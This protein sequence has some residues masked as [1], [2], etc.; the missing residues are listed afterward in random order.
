M[1]RTFLLALLTFVNTSYAQDEA[2]LYDENGLLTN[3]KDISLDLKDIYPSEPRF[4]NENFPIDFSVNF[5][6]PSYIR[7][8]R[9]YYE[10]KERIISRIQA[11]NRGKD[12]G[13]V[14]CSS[15]GNSSDR[16]DICYFISSVSYEHLDSLY[17]STSSNMTQEIK[18]EESSFYTKTTSEKITTVNSSTITSNIKAS[19]STQSFLYGTRLSTSFKTSLTSTLNSTTSIAKSLNESTTKYESK[20]KKISMIVKPGKKVS[21][22]GLTMTIQ[23]YDCHPVFPYENRRIMCFRQVE[24]NDRNSVI[25]A[26]ESD[27]TADEE[28]LGDLE[29]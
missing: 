27:F 25:R 4:I 6:L 23:M 9:D 21:V 14:F 24:T 2:Y 18:W 1:K 16:K 28:S 5:E 12:I 8:H 3:Y 7:F 10:T 20:S 19:V 13:N 22:W 17:N 15:V 29:F 11:V 26:V